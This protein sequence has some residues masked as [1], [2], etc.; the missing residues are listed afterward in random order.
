PLLE[1]ERN[2]LDTGA[3]DGAELGVLPRAEHGLLPA[4]AGEGER[5]LQRGVPQVLVAVGAWVVHVC[6]RGS[7]DLRVEPVLAYCWDDGRGVVKR[8]DCL[9][10]AGRTG[11]ARIFRRCAG[12]A[13]RST[14][15]GT[16]P[17]GRGRTGRRRAATPGRPAPC[18]GRWT[19]RRGR[20]SGCATR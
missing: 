12:P 20:P 3:V 10:Q 14:G 6:G 8:H 5:L 16:L 13:R 1:H 2:G 19:A 9:L 17:P 4:L 11:T 7:A 15:S 18:S